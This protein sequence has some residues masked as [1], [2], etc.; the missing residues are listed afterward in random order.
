M[1]PALLTFFIDISF[2]LLLNIN[3]SGQL[4]FHS[5]FFYVGN[6]LSDHMRANDEMSEDE[7]DIRFT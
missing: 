7:N 2:V 5:V 6:T 1:V 4:A 3:L